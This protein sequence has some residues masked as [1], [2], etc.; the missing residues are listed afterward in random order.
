MFTSELFPIAIPHRFE[1]TRLI[2]Q[3]DAKSCFLQALQEIHMGSCT[4]ETETYLRSLSRPIAGNH[5]H[6]YFKKLSVQLHNLQVLEETHGECLIFPCEDDGNVRGI[7]CPAEVKFVL[8]SGVKVMLVWNVLE[9]L[10]NGSSSKFLC[11]RNGF[12]EVETSK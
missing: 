6:I 10:K 11:S 7:S 8:K 4:S 5:V 2:R 9:Q 3:A 12:L 1:L